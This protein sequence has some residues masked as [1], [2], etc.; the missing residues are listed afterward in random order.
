M[1]MTGYIWIR[2]QEFNIYSWASLFIIIM[3]FVLHYIKAHSCVGIYHA[4]III[5]NLMIQF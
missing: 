2:N 4:S 3:A 1:W 5:K